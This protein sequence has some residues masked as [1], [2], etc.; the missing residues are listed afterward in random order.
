[1]LKP[2]SVSR[3]FATSELIAK[4]MITITSMITVTPSAVDSP[5]NPLALPT[6]ASLDF[7]GPNPSRAA[8]D[9]QLALPTKQRASMQVFDV[10]GR[11]VATLVDGEVE[12]GYHRVRWDGV[13]ATGSRVPSGIY[14]LKAKTE[15]LDRV[16]RIVRLQ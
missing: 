11:R 1:M 8:T 2:T 12:A 9:L 4:T 14:F 7:A 15:S 16:L 6:I 5:F 10:S 13:D 3:A